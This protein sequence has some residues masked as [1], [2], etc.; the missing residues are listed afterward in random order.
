MVAC[1]GTC[2]GV[3]FG[4]AW[5][6]I[7]DPP[8]SA[9]GSNLP[10]V[11]FP[12][13]VSRR[14]LPPP[15]AGT[16]WQVAQDDSLKTGPSPSGVTV[17]TETK[18]AFP[19]RKRASCAAV[20]P[21]TGSPKLSAKAGVLMNKASTTMA[22]VTRDRLNIGRPPFGAQ[23]NWT[24]ATN[25]WKYGF[26]CNWQKGKDLIPEV[27]LTCEDHRQAAIVR[28]SNDFRVAHRAARL[29]HS[30]HAGASQDVETVPKWKEGV[31][32]G[33]GAGRWRGR[34][35]N[36][37]P[38]RVDAAHL[39]GADPDRL[40]GARQHDGVRLQVSAD[41]PRELQASHLLGV[42][43]TIAN[44]LPSVRTTD[45]IDALLEDSPRRAAILR[46]VRRRGGRNHAQILLP[47]QRCQSAGTE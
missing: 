24:I 23:P 14:V 1:A 12:K 3:K 21:R 5:S 26:I 22:R 17:S 31:G 44:H 45:A 28:G 35:H 8:S 38:G 47:P 6:W 30:A 40:R 9:I 25:L 29:D 43:V 27:T 37:H 13:R 19:S 20:N 7:S 10:F 16:A 15:T 4:M 33:E 2:S 18:S 11:I 46:R 36:G 32:S 34:F 39:A 42:R 41:D